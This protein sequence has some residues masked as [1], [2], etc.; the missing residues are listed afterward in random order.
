MNEFEKI[1]IKA[2][3]SFKSTDEVPVPKD[4]FMRI[5]GQEKAVRMAKISAKQR[6]HLL[7]V[8]PPGTGKS[9]IARSISFILPKPKQQ[10]SVLHN[11]EKPERPILKI[12]T[13][14]DITK[15]SLQKKEPIGKIIEPEDAPISVAEELGFRCRRCGEISSP[16]LDFCPACGARK[17][18]LSDNPFDDLLIG[19]GKVGKKKVTKR[20]RVTPDGKVEVLTYE[21]YGDKIRV[22]K[23]SELRK[24]RKFGTKEA[25]KVLVP[26][27]RNTFVQATGASESELLGDV[28]HDPYGGHPEI[29]IPP[30]MRVIPGAV[31]EAHEGVLYIDELSSLDYPLQK[32]ILTAMQDKKFPITGRNTT[33]TG[34]AIKVNDVP[35]DFIFVGAMNFNDINLIHP[36]LRSRIR[37]EGYEV[38]MDVAMKDTL[39]NRA[40]IAQFVAQEIKKDGKIPHATKK[41]VEEI[42]KEAK[43]IAKIIDEVSGI[44]LRLRKL[45]G[46]VKLA[47]DLA[48]ME[49]SEFIDVHHVKEALENAKTI[50][51]QI[52]EKYSNWWKAGISDFAVPRGSTGDVR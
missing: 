11:P 22:L 52:K 6:R 7:L 23:D 30:Y 40:K 4:P 28:Q 24:L 35:C 47:G 33:S 9:L 38:L 18:I 26:L 16:N 29:G 21:V 36:A 37:G 42:I 41:A 31:H 10:I 8:G 45:A 50:E 17:D 46:V 39:L 43:R 48:V 13:I 2:Y 51:E 1:L 44:T 3:K 12:E 14:E 32:S 20:K 15:S 19:F 5:I 34:A 27:N 49:K 25:K